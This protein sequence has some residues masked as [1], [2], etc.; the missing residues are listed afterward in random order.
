[1]RLRH[2]RL[3]ALVT[4]LECLQTKLQFVHLLFMRKFLLEL[5]YISI[6]LCD[7][8][9][10]ALHL[11]LQ[12]LIGGNV[13]L[14]LLASKLPVKLPGAD[15]VLVEQVLVRQLLHQTLNYHVGNIH[16]LCKLSQRGAAE[17]LV[18]SDHVRHNALLLILFRCSFN[19]WW[20]LSIIFKQMGTLIDKCA[21]PSGILRSDYTQL[22]GS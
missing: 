20:H 11:L 14:L 6:E 5:R 19:N 4:L 16:A 3:N 8:V 12:R 17:D 9:L 2:F 13:L 22:L 18:R 10:D 1:M 15:L 7:I 21:F